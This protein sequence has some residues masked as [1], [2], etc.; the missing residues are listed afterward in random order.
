MRQLSTH[1]TIY[2]KGD[3]MAAKTHEPRKD[4]SEL[5]DKLTE[6]IASLTTSDKWREYLE[7]QSRFTRYSPQNVSLIGYQDPYA[8]QVAGY[9]TWKK[10]GRFVKKGEVGIS[11]LAP[12]TYKT[13]DEGTGEETKNIRGFRWTSVF[14]VR[15]TGGEDI[16]EIVQKLTGEDAE[17]IYEDL[18]RFANSIGSNVS[19]HEFGGGPNGDYDRVTK[20]IRIEAKNSENQRVKTLAHEL[21]HAL[22]H[23]GGETEDILNSDPKAREFRELE[24]EST[25]FVVCKALDIDSDDY[26]FGYVV[27]WA[28]GGEKAIANIKK[29]QARIQSAAKTILEPFE[30]ERERRAEQDLIFSQNAVHEELRE[31][32]QSLATLRRELD[33]KERERSISAARRDSPEDLA[34]C[35]LD[36]ERHRLTWRRTS[37]VHY[38]AADLVA[39]IDDKR[40]TLDLDYKVV[41]GEDPNPVRR[42]ELIKA[43]QERHSGD[44]ER[45]TEAANALDTYREELRQTL[46]EKNEAWIE[47]LGPIRSEDVLLEIV[48]H[49]RNFGIDDSARPFGDPESETHQQALQR[50]RLEQQ[51]S[52]SR[53]DIGLYQ[54]R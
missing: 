21:G 16:P 10:Q 45:F 34:R 28:G 8:T 46:G 40:V 13:T 35:D 42:E 1:N 15:Q 53:V 27:G 4:N 39:E 48:E 31:P 26:S 19:D 23:G 22:L 2:V 6:G 44:A 25:A 24:A 7:F 43:S 36:I 37:A 52:A 20:A 54:S 41:T 14:D 49:R 18:I 17:H 47:N 5:I 3:F 12:V 11:I 50:T 38:G 29:S 51:L 33:T 32:S 9:N 30:K